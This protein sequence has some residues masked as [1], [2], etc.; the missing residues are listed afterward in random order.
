VNLTAIREIGIKAINQ[1]VVSADLIIIDEIGKMELAVPEF[2]DS[3]VS[4]FDSPIPVLGTIGLKLH[5][6]F[7]STLKNRDDVTIFTLTP[8]T[9]STL[10]ERIRALFDL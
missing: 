10:F 1:A 7:V 6:S 4:A 8:D 3:V 5:S 9:R 2:Q